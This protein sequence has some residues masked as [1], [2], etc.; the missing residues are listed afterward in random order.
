MV[1]NGFRNLRSNR[2]DS[3]FLTISKKSK[4]GCFLVIFGLTLAMFP[5][6]QSYD[7]DVIA[8]GGALLCVELV[9]NFEKF[10]NFIGRSGEKRE[11]PSTCANF[12]ICVSV[13]FTI[14]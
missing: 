4:N 11:T 13:D 5:N 14:E 8:H 6:S 7:F 3:Q 12:V 2:M 9:S 10:E 1:Q